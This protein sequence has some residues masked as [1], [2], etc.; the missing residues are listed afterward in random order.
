MDHVVPAVA[1]RQPGLRSEAIVA[2]E[3]TEPICSVVS[4]TAVEFDQQLERVVPDVAAVGKTQ[5]FLL[6]TA[7]RAKDR[8]VV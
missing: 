6:P 5:P 1:Q 3:V 4:D 8:V 7:A 2:V